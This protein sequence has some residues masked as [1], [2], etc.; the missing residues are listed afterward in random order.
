MYEAKRKNILCQTI[1]SFIFTVLEIFNKIYMNLK[2]GI[3]KNCGFL[4][5]MKL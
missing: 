3:W 5:S 2:N 1:Q 4:G